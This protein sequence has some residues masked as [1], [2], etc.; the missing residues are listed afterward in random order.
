VKRSR[1]KGWGPG[2]WLAVGWLGLVVLAALFRDLWPVDPADQDLRASLQPPSWDHPLGTNKLG[3]DML[4]LIIDGARVSVIVGVVATAIGLVLG[5]LLGMV[6]GYFRGRVDRAVVIVLDAAIAFPSLVL[7]L[8]VVLYW[9]QSLRNVTLIIGV[10]TAPLFARVL[11]TATLTIVDRDFVLAA[12]MLGAR[13]RRVIGTDVVPNVV[14][15]VLAYGLIAMGAVILVEGALSYFGLGVPEGTTSWGRL[16]AEG[17]VYLEDAPWVSLTPAAAIFFTILALNYLGDRVQARWFAGGPI[18]KMP[19]VRAVAV[20]PSAAAAVVD[21]DGPLLDVRDLV[22]QLATPFGTVTAVDGVSFA[23]QRGR[24][25]AI[26]GESGSGKTMLARSIAGLVPT[27]PAV[28][29]TPGQVLFEG[30]NLKALAAD[31]LRRV[32]GREIAMVFQD[33]MTSLD[34]V[35]KV[36]HQIAEPVRVHLDV[37]RKHARGVAMQLLRDVGIPDPERRF[38]QYPHQLSGGLRQR[39]AIAIALSCGPKLLIADE[40][41]SALDVTVQAQILDLLQRLQRDRNMAV[42]LITHDLGVVANRADEVA[43][44]YGARIVEQAGTAA[45]FAAPRMPYT[46]ALLA[47]APALG[48]ASHARLVAIEGAPPSLLFP[49]P[50]CRFAPRCARATP[51]CTA[52]APPLE[53]DG[54]LAAC[55]HPLAADHEAAGVAA[56]G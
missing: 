15:P 24:M 4:A 42:I 16:V 35:M 31:D 21:Q 12:R 40:P 23:L 19:K 20:S 7:A 32:R 54:H 45:L 51:E 47:S 6:A 22:T 38:H 11:R 26:V 27:P 37:S 36:G 56:S 55:W 13:H 25:L 43:V 53:G 1:W 2:F 17:Q 49:P 10:L 28:P 52:A 18:P 34:P 48:A 41:T 33:P 39:V 30:R 50:G 14:V 8:A 3:Q 29:G 5:A 9:G 44:M 46:A